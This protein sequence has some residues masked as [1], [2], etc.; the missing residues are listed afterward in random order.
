LSGFETAL[1]GK[2]DCDNANETKPPVS[3]DVLRAAWEAQFGN[4]DGACGP[5]YH[6]SWQVMKDQ[7]EVDRSCGFTRKPDG[8]LVS[9]AGCTA[10][11]IGPNGTRTPGCPVTLTSRAYEHDTR[12]AAHEFAHWALRCSTGYSDPNHTNAAVYG[13]NGYAAR[14]AA[15]FPAR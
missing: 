11:T 3:E 2:V 1:T 5:A 10:Y 9:A 12:L 8:R 4:L 13:P 15:L 14:V 7:D 6:W